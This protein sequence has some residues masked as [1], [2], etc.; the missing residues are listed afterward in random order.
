MFT[1]SRIAIVMWSEAILMMTKNVKFFKKCRQ[2]EVKEFF[3][4]LGK[5]GENRNRP[6]VREQGRVITFENGKDLG[7]SFP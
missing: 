5:T 7:W 1:N 6:V 3:K 4:H 2:S